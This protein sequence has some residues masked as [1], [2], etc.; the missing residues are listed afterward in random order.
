MQDC[1]I[2]TEKFLKSTSFFNDQ[3]EILKIQE[4]HF[5]DSEIEFLKIKS[6]TVAYISSSRPNRV[7]YCKH[8]GVI[9]YSDLNFYNEIPLEE[10]KKIKKKNS[11]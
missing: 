3:Y 9:T 4:H 10:N 11:N 5:I 8:C 1:I 2:R 6:T 7:I